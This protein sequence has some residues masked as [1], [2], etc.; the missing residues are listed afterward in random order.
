MTRGYLSVF[1]LAG[2]MGACAF[3]TPTPTPYQPSGYTGG[4][5]DQ[6]L[7]QTQ[8]LVSVSGNG[9][10]SEMTLVGY[11]HRRATE[12][13]RSIGYSGYSFELS[14]QATQTQM[15]PKTYTVDPVANVPTAVPAAA[16][17]G[18]L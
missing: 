17:T 4:Y 15:T 13:C 12:L 3:F 10:T 11:F 7:G 18:K 6:R 8:F 16:G 5:Q 9:N 2:G 14:T 1:L